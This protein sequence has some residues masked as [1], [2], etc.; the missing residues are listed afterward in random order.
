MLRRTEFASSRRQA[1][2]LTTKSRRL[3]LQAE[4]AAVV[5]VAVVLDRIRRQR[6]R[7][8]AGKMQLASAIIV[9]VGATTSRPEAGTN[10]AV[11]TPRGAVVRRLPRMLMLLQP[12]RRKRK[13]RPL[14]KP[15]CR[16]LVAAD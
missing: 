8:P 10:K 6:R 5:T 1:F 16:E 7:G 11:G 9:V 12:I 14:Q 13:T 15:D 2:L 3:P 4:E